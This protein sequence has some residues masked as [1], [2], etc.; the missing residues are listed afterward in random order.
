MPSD[1]R[2]FSSWT[3]PIWEQ[4]RA[5]ENVWNGAAAWSSSRFNLS[6]GGQTEFINGRWVS[7]G[8]FDLLGVRAILGRTIAPADDARGGGPDGAV[9]VISYGYWQR[10]FG[11]AADVLGRTLTLERVPYAIVGVVPPDFFGP[12]VG[13]RFDVAVPIGTEPLQ[14]GKESGLDHRSMWWLASWSG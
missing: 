9:A 6:Q 13:R 11:G 1:D 10:R 4:I 14:R 7:G 3:N 8:F 5:R 12:D 2:V